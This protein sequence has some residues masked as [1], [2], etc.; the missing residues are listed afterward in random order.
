MSQAQQREAAAAEAT[1][2]DDPSTPT[3]PPHPA[4]PV[5]LQTIQ[6]DKFGQYRIYRKLPDHE[7]ENFPQP[8]HNNFT[9][10][11]HQGNSEDLASGLRMPI[12]SF[13]NLPGIVG[14][15]FNATIALLVQ[16]FYSGTSTK[17]LTDVQHLIDNVI[18]HEDFQAED[19]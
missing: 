11:T 6:T 5:E 1:G 9:A 2:Q 15:F 4:T 19:L 14:S 7:P 10:E 8:D 18:L 12:T 17:S 13:S 3:P 16:W